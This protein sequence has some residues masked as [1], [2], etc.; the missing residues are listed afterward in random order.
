MLNTCRRR[1]TPEI[2]EVVLLCEQGQV[3]GTAD[4]RVIHTDST[5][6]HSA[7]SIFLFN[8]NGEMLTQQR[9]WSKKTWPGIWS[10]ACCGHPLPGESHEAAAHR[11]LSDELGLTGLQLKLALPNFRYRAE[12]HGIVE[13]EICPVFIGRCDQL[14]TINPDEV[15]AT[16]WTSWDSFA[17][18]AF[19][20][21]GTG[22]EA[23]SPWSLLEAQQLL[24]TEQLQQLLA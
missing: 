19:N 17:R 12:L 6:L 7:F 9:A 15:A 13:N 2:E 18:A 5:P 10:N 24:Q 4:K 16:A 11:R 1:T 14:P 21:N 3:I 22:F 23:F 20:A 8:E